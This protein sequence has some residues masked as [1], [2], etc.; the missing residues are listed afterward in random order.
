MDVQN[1]M[2]FVENNREHHPV[3]VG[4]KNKKVCNQICWKHF[5]RSS[6]ELEIIWVYWMDHSNHILFMWSWVQVSLYYALSISES[7]KI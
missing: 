7:E 2:T 1:M 3:A 4:K 5:G 6:A